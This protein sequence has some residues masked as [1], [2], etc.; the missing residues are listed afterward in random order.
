MRF[1]LFYA[2][3]TAAAFYERSDSSYRY[4]ASTLS[5][6][7]RTLYVLKRSWLFFSLVV[8]S[9]HRLSRVLLSINLLIMPAIA[10]CDIFAILL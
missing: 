8:V 4:V 7:A 3:T 1:K 2:S 5:S 10:Y 9:A 6:N